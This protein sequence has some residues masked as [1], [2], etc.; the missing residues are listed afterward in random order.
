[1]TQ[2]HPNPTS[3]PHYQLNQITITNTDQLTFSL[4]Q[5]TL[6]NKILKSITRYLLTF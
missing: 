1:M 2:N 6:A 3:Q 5:A 4:F